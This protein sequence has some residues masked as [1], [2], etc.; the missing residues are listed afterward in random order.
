MVTP[1]FLAVIFFTGGGFRH[2][3][4]TGIRNDAL[5]LSPAGVA[6]YSVMSARGTICSW[7]VLRATRVR[8]YDVIN[9]RADTDFSVMIFS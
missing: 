9:H 5:H 8:P 1:T 6:D 7:F 3:G 2:S 4:N